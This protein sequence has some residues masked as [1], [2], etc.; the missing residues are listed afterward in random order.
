MYS[1]RCVGTL[2]TAPHERAQ[3]AHR[4][5]FFPVTDIAS[6]RQQLRGYPATHWKGNVTRM[7]D[8][9]QVLRSGTFRA[10]VRIFFFFHF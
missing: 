10:S 7:S 2:E 3:L 1:Y 6:E 4:F 9:V 8:K 5:I